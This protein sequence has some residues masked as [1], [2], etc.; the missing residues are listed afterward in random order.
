MAR[1]VPQP[2][3][4]P[5]D[6]K[7][8]I[9]DHLR[10][11]AMFVDKAG[12]TAAILD[13][14]DFYP[15]GGVVPGVGKTTS[16]NTIKFSGRYR[17]S[18]TTANLDYFGA[19]YYSNTVGRF[20]SPDWADSPTTVP[21]AR[22]GDPQTLNLYSYTENAPINRVDLDGHFDDPFG[23]FGSG[24]SGMSNMQSRF[25]QPDT[26]NNEA[27]GKNKKHATH[28]AQKKKKPKRTEAEIRRKFWKKYGKA[29]NAALA[30][31]FGKD[32]GKI[33]PQTAA[34]MPKLDTSHSEAQLTA[35]KNSKEAIVGGNSPDTSHYMTEGSAAKNGTI[36]I[37]SE[38]WQGNDEEEIFKTIAHEWANLLDFQ[39]NGY[40][41]TEKNYADPNET[42]TDR[43]TGMH[44][45]RTMWPPPA[46]SP[47]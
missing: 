44:V 34:G 8:Y 37:S 10:S 11:T 16:N 21:Y 1:N 47:P 3:P 4:N 12:T 23:V 14:N 27:A 45:E 17:D 36:R 22:F 30:K 2:A 43:D 15:W 19:R 5:A 41:N 33:G 29:F 35:K 25:Y 40:Q 46:Q 38:D 6:I 39:I 7:Y 9:T 42:S 20:V 31:V 32:F 18:E 24:D 28:K 13:D 26:R